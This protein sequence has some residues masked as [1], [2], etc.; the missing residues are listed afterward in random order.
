M[1]NV[2]IRHK[3]EYY[4]TVI[5]V[6]LFKIMPAKLATKTGMVIGSFAYRALK[7]RRKVVIDNLKQAFPD[8]SIEELNRIALNSYRHW[9]GVGAEFARLTKI[10]RKFCHKYIDFEGEEVLNECRDMGKGTLIIAGHLGNWEI[11][12]AVCSILGYN[13][14]YVVA[15]Q[16]N[17]LVDNLMDE[18]RRFHDIEI[19]KTREAPRGVLRSLRDNRFIALMIDQ[20]A[21]KECV[22]VNFFGKLASTHR[23]PAVFYQRTQSP[24]VMSSCIRI[25]GLHYKIKFEKISLPEFGGRNKEEINRRIM[26]YV[27]SIL[28]EK[29]RSYP[30][31]YFWLHKRW[32]TQPPD[33]I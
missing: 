23:G 21:G 16:T 3:F 2:N 33:E 13:V 14:T 11:M 20:D 15:S 19:W 30:E 9:G 5:M 32:K 26:Q 27:T 1:Q 25:K 8:K 24:M 4:L 17:K 18:V 29:V 10:N 31:Q 28:E 6:A 12:G 7:I 22:F